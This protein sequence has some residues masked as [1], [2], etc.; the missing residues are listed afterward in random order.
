MHVYTVLY[1]IALRLRVN[2]IKPKLFRGLPGLRGLGGGGGGGG[3]PPPEFLYFLVDSSPYR[4]N[5]TN[6]TKYPVY[7]K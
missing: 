7:N 6:L 5:H 4:L 3:T 1:H 2:P